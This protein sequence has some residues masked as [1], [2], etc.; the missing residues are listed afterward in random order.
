M[1]ASALA[2][3]GDVV[4][5]IESIEQFV[6]RLYTS[7]ARAFANDRHFSKFLRRLA[8]DERSG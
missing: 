2:D 1:V 6:G 4:N 3:I 5:W 7:A 8:E